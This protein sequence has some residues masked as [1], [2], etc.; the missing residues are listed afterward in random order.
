[1]VKTRDLEVLRSLKSNVIIS[2]N[3]CLDACVL[4]VF[5]G[6][7][8]IKSIMIPIITPIAPSK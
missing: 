6:V 7:S 1:M 2:I 5:L 4:A 3:D 8:F